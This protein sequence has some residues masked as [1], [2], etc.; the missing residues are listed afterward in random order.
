M[1]RRGIADLLFSGAS[2]GDPDNI[3][4]VQQVPL[5][6][7]SVST[8]KHSC[9]V[10]VFFSAVNSPGVTCV[11]LL[12]YK[13]QTDRVERHRFTVW[14][15]PSCETTILW[16]SKMT[17]FEGTRVSELNAK[18]KRK[19]HSFHR[20]LCVCARVCLCSVTYQ[21]PPFCHVQ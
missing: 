16:A 11:L 2:L 9:L 6:L 18:L 8:M 13:P 19:P 12:L 5:K 15:F 17:N 3:W 10:F 21:K 14:D 4:I 1:G 7:S 20:A